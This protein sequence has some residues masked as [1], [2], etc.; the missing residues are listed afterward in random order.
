MRAKKF[1]FD[2]VGSENISDDDHHI[3]KNRSPQALKLDA[4]VNR[5]P[6]DEFI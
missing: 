1:Y 2:D 3:K 5:I 6:E 4:N